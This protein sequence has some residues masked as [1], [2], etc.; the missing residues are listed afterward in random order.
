MPPVTSFLASAP[1][2]PLTLDVSAPAMFLSDLHFGDGTR[3]DLFLGQDGTLISLLERWCDERRTIVFLGDIL[4]M[5]QAWSVR[6][7][8]VAHRELLR[9]LARVSIATRVVFVRGNHD[10][11]VDYEGLFPGATCCDA[12]LLGSRILAWHG[13]QAD[14]V[15]N[16]GAGNAAIKTYAHALLE[17]AARCR[18][19]PPLPRYDSAANRVVLALATALSRANLHRARGLRARGRTERADAMEAQVRYLARSFLGD[20]ADIFGVTTRTLLGDPFDTVVCGHTHV[21][22]IVRTARGAYV[23]TG[24]WTCGSR[25]YAQWT[26]ERFVVAEV[27]SGR[28]LGDEGF[29][30]LP[31]ETEPEDLFRWWAQHHKGFLRFEF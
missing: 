6:R 28:E 4:D 26:G 19:V 30:S 14:L 10:W 16:P 12:V 18:L 17:R 11:S 3:T 25:T 1:Q 5:P 22:G 13:H 8:R 27:D 7:I 15:M 21:P 9:T 20:P 29:A 31:A 23:N 2:H 24:S